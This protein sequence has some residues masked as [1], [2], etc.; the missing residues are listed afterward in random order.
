MTLLSRIK[1][2]LSKCPHLTYVSIEVEI[3]GKE[4]VLTGEV[5]SFYHKQM[6]QV[7]IRHFQGIDGLSIRNKLKVKRGDY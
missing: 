3:I 6:A 7:A 2:S 5:K 1:S 4:I